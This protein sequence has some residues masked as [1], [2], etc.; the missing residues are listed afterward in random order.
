MKGLHLTFIVALTSVAWAQDIHNH[1]REV[2]GVPGGVP[3]FCAQSTVTSVAGGAW[4]NPATWSTGKVP[5]SDDRVAI[6]AWHDI[7]YDVASDAKLTCVEIRGRLRFRPD[8]NT[9]IKTANL[10]VMDEG[11]LEVG[12]ADSPIAANVTAEIIIADQKIDRQLDPA[13]LGA[14]IESLGKITMHGAM[15]SPTFVRLTQEPLAGQTTLTLTEC[16]RL[17]R[18]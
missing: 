2:H 11:Y 3:E 8:A 17:E 15:K 12:S 1:P 13:E 5:A 14:G 9:R 6:A 7:V 16:E 4:S 18:G 10:M